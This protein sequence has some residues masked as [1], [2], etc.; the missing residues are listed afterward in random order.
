MLFWRMPEKR[1]GASQ[2]SFT[3]TIDGVARNAQ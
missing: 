2:N 1:R 3:D